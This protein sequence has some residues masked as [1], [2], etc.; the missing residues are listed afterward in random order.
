MAIHREKIKKYG[1]NL[2]KMAK[3]GPKMAKN[4]N[5]HRFLDIFSKFNN[6]SNIFLTDK[7]DPGKDLN[8]LFHIK[9]TP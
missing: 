6:F 3:I 2:S 5:F 1:K 8:S 4:G 7:F 9:L